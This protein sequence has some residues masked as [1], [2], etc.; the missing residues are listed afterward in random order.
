[1]KKLTLLLTCVSFVVL[2]SCGGKAS[3][4]TVA[5]KWCELNAKFRSATND[6]DKQAAKEA[7]NKYENEIESKYKSDEKFMSKLKELTQACD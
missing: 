1:M 7:R 4:D 6:T 3:V 5:K 2:S